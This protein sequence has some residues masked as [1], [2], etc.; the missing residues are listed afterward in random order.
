MATALVTEAMLQPIVDGI[1]AN[2]GVILPIGVTIMG[3]VVSV[4]LI[5]RILQKFL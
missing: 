5:P 2:V 1:T 4:G 3:I